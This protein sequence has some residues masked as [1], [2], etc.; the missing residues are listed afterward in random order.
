MVRPEVWVVLPAFEQSISKTF[1]GLDKNESYTFKLSEKLNDEFIRYF[2]LREGKL[3]APIILR[4]RDRDYPAKVRWARM[5]R[6]KTV[7]YKPSDLPKRDG[8]FFE[9]AADDH[10]ITQNVIHDL[11]RDEVDSISSGGSCPNRKFRFHH[12]HDNVFLFVALD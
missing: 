2:G 12:L 8:I 9:W 3:F 11:F 7:K 10:R 5:N 6:E 1:L 4:I